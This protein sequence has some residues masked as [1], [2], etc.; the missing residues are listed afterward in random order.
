MQRTSSAAARFENPSFWSLLSARPRDEALIPLTDLLKAT[1]TSHSHIYSTL[2]T[3]NTL[4]PQV[5]YRAF[6]IQRQAAGNTPEKLGLEFF[7]TK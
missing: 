6:K 5:R 4:E 7:V 2:K 1:S 3:S